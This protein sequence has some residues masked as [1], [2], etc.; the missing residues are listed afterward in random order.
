MYELPHRTLAYFDEIRA[1]LRVRRDPWG[2]WRPAGGRERSHQYRER[3]EG[4][5][6][7]QARCTAVVEAGE[8]ERSDVARCP[9][10]LR[11]SGGDQAGPRGTIDGV[12]VGPPME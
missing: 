8:W 11:L 7:G 9:K 5:P 10:C 6:D 1:G 4:I 3:R 2:W 12:A